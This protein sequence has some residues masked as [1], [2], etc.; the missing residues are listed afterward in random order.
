[1]SQSCVTHFFDITYKPRFSYGRVALETK[2][3][4]EHCDTMIH[5][6]VGQIHAYQFVGRE[7]RGTLSFAFAADACGRVGSECRVDEAGS[8]IRH[9]EQYGDDACAGGEH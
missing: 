6:R 9:D 1:M 8:F 2:R 4:S 5:R 7:V 3:V